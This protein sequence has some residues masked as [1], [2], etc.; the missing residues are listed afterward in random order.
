MEKNLSGTENRL[1][2]VV[3]FGSETLGKL[4]YNAI[5]FNS[6]DFP[7]LIDPLLQ[8]GNTESQISFWVYAKFYRDGN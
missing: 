8:N 4:G 3:P 7:K 2:A 5:L 6:A 1:N